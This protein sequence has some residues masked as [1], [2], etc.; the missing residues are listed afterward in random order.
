MAKQ[1]INSQQNGGF[2]EELGRTTLGTAGTTI[3]L[4]NIPARKNL[5]LIIQGSASGGTLAVALRF[6]N[7]SNTN[8]NYTVVYNSAGDSVYT[9]SGSFSQAQASTTIVSGGSFNITGDVYNP[10][11]LNKLAYLASAAEITNT[12]NGYAPAIEQ[13]SIKWVNASQ[14]TRIDAIIQAGTGN[15]AVGSELIVLGHN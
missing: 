12:A 1:K 5:R 14:I 13:Y 8:Y 6:N 9:A 2:W 15:F 11:T 4:T 10:S 3:S 7:D